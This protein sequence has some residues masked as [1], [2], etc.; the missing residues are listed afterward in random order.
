MRRAPPIILGAG[1]AGSAAA[2]RLA[3]AG[4]R[5]RL[6]DQQDV[7]GDAL[8]GGFLSWATIAQLADLGLTGE[9]LGGHPITTV[10]LFAGGRE[11]RLALPAPGMGLSRRRLDTLLRTIA[12][13]AGARL[14]IGRATLLSPT[15]LTL[16]DGE[17]IAW[18]SLF[19]A[20]GKH[21]LRG[22]GRPHG[23]EDPELGLRV[24]LPAG[25]ALQSLIGD[26]IELHMVPGGYVGLLLQE[27]GSAN[28]C[29]AVRKS[30]LAAAG[31]RPLALFHQL[32]DQYP[33]LGQRLADLSADTRIDAIGHVPYGWRARDSWPGLYRLGDQAA[34]VPSLAG[35]GMGIALASAGRAVQRWEA[36]GRDGARAYQRDFARR[37][38]R[39]LAA[40][41]AF[42]TLSAHPRL[43]RALA[44]TPGAAALAMRLT[45]I[46][47][48]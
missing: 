46:V 11:D 22:A 5:P 7:P 9:Q 44:R 47:P 45:R 18:D 39:P 31:G 16:D 30:R 36:D 29:M 13:E 15:A 38:T 19:L 8:C 40:A 33:A 27:D 41:A 3:R 35:E 24:K 25:P 6:I 34:V 48:S 17:P 12:V 10:A 2:I 4:A 32:A 37:A 14:H 23:G 1:P 43:L 20:T 42:R 26:R 28:I 21:D